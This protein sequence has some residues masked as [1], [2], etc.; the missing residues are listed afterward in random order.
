MPGSSFRFA[1]ALPRL[2]RTMSGVL[3]AAARE[4]RVVES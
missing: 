2:G 3:V 4:E 1:P